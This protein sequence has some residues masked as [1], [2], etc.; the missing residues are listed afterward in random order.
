MNALIGIAGQLGCLAECS[1]IDAC[2]AHASR[3]PHDRERRNDGERPRSG[4][5]RRSRRNEFEDPPQG[6]GTADEDARLRDFT[7]NALLYDVGTGEVIDYV[8]GVRDLETRTLRTIGEAVVRIA[9][10]PVRML[11]AIKFASRLDLH[12]D[13]I[14]GGIQAI[15]AVP[16]AGWA[17]IIAV[18]GIHELTI[19]KQDYTKTPGEIPTFLGF[20]PDDPEVRPC[21]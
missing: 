1:D 15:G 7:I 16:G 14:P 21:R 9:E 17:Q 20:K 4:R 12:F 10:D 11:R 5:R 8:G 18:V 6:Y 3:A 13:D 19:N 2:D